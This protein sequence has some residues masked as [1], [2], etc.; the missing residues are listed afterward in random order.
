M[1]LFS[2]VQPQLPFGL[3]FADVCAGLSDAGPHVSMDLGSESSKDSTRQLMQ[4]ILQQDSTN[5]TL[6]VSCNLT[7]ASQQTEA[8]AEVLSSRSAESASCGQRICHT[9][10][11]SHVLSSPAVPF[12]LFVA[13]SG[14]LGMH[15][16]QF[17]SALFRAVRLIG[18]ATSATAHT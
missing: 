2:P 13:H 4:A 1:T 14:K 3:T 5:G 17:E 9:G 8:I 16:S 7:L 15:P 18:L 10:K 12:D 6:G 11:L